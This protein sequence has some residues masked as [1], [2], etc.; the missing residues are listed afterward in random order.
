MFESI[1]SG[2]PVRGDFLQENRVQR[3]SPHPSEELN[4][5]RLVCFPNPT[6]T[7]DYCW[8]CRLGRIG[9]GHGSLKRPITRK[10]SKNRISYP[11]K[12]PIRFPEAS[13]CLRLYSNLGT[14]IKHR[15]KATIHSARKRSLQS[16]DLLHSPAGRRR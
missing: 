7:T 5:C 4:R 15:P 10:R 16:R 9:I 8:L 1:P 3:S 11:E 2:L 14:A 6:S 12:Q 13:H